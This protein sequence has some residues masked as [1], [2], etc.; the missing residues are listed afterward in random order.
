MS[1]GARQLNTTPYTAVAPV[2]QFPPFH[3]LCLATL[4]K[5]LPLEDTGIVSSQQA[6]YGKQQR[7][8]KF[9]GATRNERVLKIAI[10]PRCEVFCKVVV[11]QVACVDFF[12]EDIQ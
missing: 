7:K 2:P 4:I 12:Q 10:T 1:D 9:E 8:L 11:P 3:L 5:S 6:P